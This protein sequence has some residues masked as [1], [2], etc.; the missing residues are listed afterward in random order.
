MNDD[1]SDTLSDSLHLTSILVLSVDLTDKRL[2]WCL[3][4]DFGWHEITIDFKR[5]RCA[6]PFRSYRNKRIW[7]N[8]TK[9][10]EKH[11]SSYL[12][13][14]RNIWLKQSLRIWLD[15]ELGQ[16]TAL[17]RTIAVWGQSN[18]IIRTLQDLYLHTITRTPWNHHIKGAECWAHHYRHLTE[19]NQLVNRRT[20]KQPLVDNVSAAGKG[21]HE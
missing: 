21:N 1:T 9:C 15:I 8:H 20:T 11:P 4:Y 16:R 12:S 2:N 17:L 3:S 13:I 19:R 6:N 18:I 10:A 14:T 5:S 7:P